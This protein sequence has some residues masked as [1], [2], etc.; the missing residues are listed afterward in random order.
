MGAIIADLNERI[1]LPPVELVTNNGTSEHI[2]DQRSC[3]ENAHRL[4]KVDG[5]MIHVLPF[6]PWVNHGFFNYNP[7]LFRDLAIANEYETDLFAIGDRNARLK[8]MGE[9]AF[10]EKRPEQL[11]RTLNKVLQTGE[12]FVIAV[13]KKV[14]DSEFCLPFQGKYKTDIQAKDLEAKY[15]QP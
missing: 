9:E 15:V 6:H 4:C 12:A 2:F 7:I 3:F 10:V 13:F 14:K 11:I 5:C 8:E 1:D